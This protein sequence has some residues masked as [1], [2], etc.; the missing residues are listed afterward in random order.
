MSRQWTSEYNSENQ[1]R[2]ESMDLLI[3]NVLTCVSLL[4]AWVVIIWLRAKVRRLER[5]LL[6]AEGRLFGQVEWDRG[7]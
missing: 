6:I 3:G 7:H 5:R 4:L 1:E 2:T